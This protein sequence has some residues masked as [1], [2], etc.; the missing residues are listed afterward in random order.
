MISSGEQC[1]FLRGN[2]PGY[3]DIDKYPSEA[4]TSASQLLL[5]PS[6]LFERKGLAY[7]LVQKMP[8]HQIDAAVDLAFPVGRFSR[9]AV[10]L[11]VFGIRSAMPSQR[12]FRGNRS[13]ACFFR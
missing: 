6:H 8:V 10:I 11:S 5:S 4:R 2:N 12:R 7:G 1:F 9:N 3:S 13:A